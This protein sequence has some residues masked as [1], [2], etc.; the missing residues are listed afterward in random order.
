RKELC[1]TR[2]AISELTASHRKVASPLIHT[3]LSQLLFGLTFSVGIGAVLGGVISVFAIDNPTVRVAVQGLNVT[4]IIALV[5]FSQIRKRMERLEQKRS[6]DPELEIRYW[7]YA[8]SC[9][10]LYLLGFIL[11]LASSILIAANWLRQ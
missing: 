5:A 9:I 7:R 4:G 2:Q 1:E 8:L 6:D 3:Y 10:V 11:F